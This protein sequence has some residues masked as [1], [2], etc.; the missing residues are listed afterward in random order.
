MYPPE[1]SSCTNQL[2][3]PTPRGTQVCHVESFRLLKK[4][5]GR[6]GKVSPGTN[7]LLF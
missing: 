6:S 3:L 4:A 5:L 1:I 2:V 7:E